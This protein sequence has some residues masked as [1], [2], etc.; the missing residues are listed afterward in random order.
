MQFCCIT[1]KRLKFKF[2]RQHTSA[3]H[4]QRYLDSFSYLRAS[5][6]VVKTLLTQKCFSYCA[7]EFNPSGPSL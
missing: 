4:L 2:A 5:N 6:S 3:K 7:T 1:S